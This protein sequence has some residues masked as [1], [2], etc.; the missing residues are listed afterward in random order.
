M[1]I[2]SLNIFLKAVGVIGLIFMML[3]AMVYWLFVFLKKTF[4]NFKFWI[5]YKIFR[6]K[7]PV[8]LNEIVLSDEEITINFY[9]D[10]LIKG[11]TPKLAK[12]IIY[13]KKMKGGK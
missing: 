7:I 11:Y 10:L 3:S 2:P 13:L 9:K 8:E 4:P 5:K 1:E 12:E 6:K